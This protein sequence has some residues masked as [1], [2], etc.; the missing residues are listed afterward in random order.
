MINMKKMNKKQA[1]F[2]LIELVMVIVILGILSAFALPRFADLT[3]DAREASISGLAGALKSAAAIAHSQQ[4]ADGTS[5]STAVTLDNESILMVEGFPTTA[6]GGITL[7]ANVDTA[8]DYTAAV[9]AATVTY[10]LPGYTP[11]TGT[12]CQAVYTAATASS[13]Y[14]VVVTDDGCG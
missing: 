5:S 7:A 12:F 3:G 14:K 9:L 1:G 2:T 6:A 13:S 10:T 8:N 4:V 11:P